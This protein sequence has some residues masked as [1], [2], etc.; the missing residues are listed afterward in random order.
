MD[1]TVCVCLEI[2]KL[3]HYTLTRLI[4][5]LIFLSHIKLCDSLLIAVCLL[6]GLLCGYQIL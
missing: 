5:Q 6:E 4:L 1:C 3:E 2:K